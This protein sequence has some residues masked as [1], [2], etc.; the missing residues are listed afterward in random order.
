MNQ[1]TTLNTKPTQTKQKQIEALKKHPNKKQRK[2]IKT[3][4]NERKPKTETRKWRTIIKQERN[5]AK[6]KHKNNKKTTNKS[7]EETSR[8]RKHENR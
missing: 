2:S 4:S 7:N 3:R 1:T 6:T 8:K 5:N